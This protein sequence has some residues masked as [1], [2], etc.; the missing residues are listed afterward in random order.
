MQESQRS[1][2]SSKKMETQYLIA[3]RDPGEKKKN[4]EKSDKRP[5]KDYSLVDRIVFMLIF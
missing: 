2:Q 4:N 1:C 5:N 3:M